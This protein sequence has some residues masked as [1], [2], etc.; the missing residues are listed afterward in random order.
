MFLGGASNPLVLSGD[1]T[2]ELQTEDPIA[3]GLLSTPR[4]GENNVAASHQ[5]PDCPVAAA[6]QELTTDA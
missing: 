2:G 5:H 1:T 6:R 4:L 3:Q